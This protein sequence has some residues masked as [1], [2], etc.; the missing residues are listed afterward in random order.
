MSRIGK[1]P[2]K[3]EN[4]VNVDIKDKS[5]VMLKNGNSVQQIQFTGPIEAEVKDGSIFVTRKNDEAQTR[6][7]HG[8]YRSLVQNA[9]IG[10]SKG[11][12]KSLILN[13]VGYRANVAGKFLELT[14]GFSHPIKFPI[15]TGI[16]ASVDKQTTVTIKGADKALVGQVAAIIRGFRPPEP[17]LGKGIRY[18]DEKIRRKAGKSGGK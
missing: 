6:A 5:F 15:P 9:M 17:Y 3:V 1:L 12:E 7:L 8:L 10:V 18:S 14:L 16:E 11:W 13:G 4:K 2:I